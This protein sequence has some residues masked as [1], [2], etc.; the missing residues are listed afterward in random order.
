[1]GDEPYAALLPWMVFAVVDRA[2]GG[3]PLWAAVGALITAVTL[4]VTSSRDES[5]APNVMVLGATAWF[6]GLTVAAAIYGSNTGFL[7]RDGRALSAAAFAAIAFG[8]LAFMPAIEH[9]TRRHVRSG[10][11]DD[12]EFHHVNVAITLIWAIAFTGIS[13]GYVVGTSIGTPKAFTVFHWVVP[14]AIGAIAAHRTRLAWEEFNDTDDFE[15][16]PMS[17]LALDWD[18]RSGRPVSDA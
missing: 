11:W 12:P 5:R 18:D 3:G 7:D 2:Q 1:V 4:L 13:I 14:L 6:G 9:Y 16:D 15:P 10:R 8:S 17:D